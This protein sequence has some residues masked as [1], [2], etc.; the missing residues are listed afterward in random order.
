MFVKKVLK[1]KNSSNVKSA[2]H[3][4]KER[5]GRWLIWIVF[6]EM[7]LEVVVVI[8]VLFL[9]SVSNPNPGSPVPFGP[10]DPGSGMG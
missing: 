10:L 6:S 1:K 3:F 9:T 5:D 8:A 7:Y 2:C 4:A